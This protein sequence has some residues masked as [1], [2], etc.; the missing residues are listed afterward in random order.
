MN[1]K[2]WIALAGILLFAGLAFSACSGQ[3]PVQEKLGRWEIKTGSQGATV[4]GEAGMQ[5]IGFDVR[6]VHGQP[7]AYANVYYTT[8]S[9]GAARSLIGVTS[10]GGAVAWSDPKLEEV[11]LEIDCGLEK[12]QR[13]QI[14]LEN[15]M[16]GKVVTLYTSA[17]CSE[18]QRRWTGKEAVFQILDDSG[19]P[20]SHVQ[21]TLAQLN[22]SNAQQGAF[23]TDDQGAF[24]WKNPHRQTMLIQITYQGQTYSWQVK[25]DPASKQ[26]LLT[27][28]GTQKQ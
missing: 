26:T 20:V 27:T 21:V 6:D 17:A 25:A 11:C 1:R 14:P 18:T 15:S 24:I 10:E 28:Q 16:L 9:N 13:I 2:R 4:A 12:A 7:V 23:V 22:G 5:A 19:V 8:L 3:N